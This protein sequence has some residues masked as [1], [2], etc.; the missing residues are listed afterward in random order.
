MFENKYCMEI[1]VYTMYSL[2]VHENDFLGWQTYR[3]VLFNNGSLTCKQVVYFCC[4]QWHC[5][6]FLALESSA[7]RHWF[8]EKQISSLSYH[9]KKKAFCLLPKNNVTFK[10]DS[11]SFV[12]AVSCEKSKILNQTLVIFYRCRALESKGHFD[13]AFGANS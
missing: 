7:Q 12:K 10:K 4:Q 11:F 3:L 9:N 6:W 5:S 13:C 1:T 8:N 2:G